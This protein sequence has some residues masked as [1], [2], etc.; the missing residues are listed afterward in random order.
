MPLYTLAQA[1]MKGTM[2]GFKQTIDQYVSDKGGIEGIE[3]DN[4]LGSYI[5]QCSH[6]ERCDG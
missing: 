1:T 2:K 4:T 3:A 5:T 6:P